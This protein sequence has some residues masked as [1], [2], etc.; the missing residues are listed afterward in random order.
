MDV[1]LDREGEFCQQSWRNMSAESK[2][3]FIIDELKR[4][5]FKA[6]GKKWMLRDG[7]IVRYISS[8]GRQG[9]FGGRGRNRNPVEWWDAECLQLVRDRRRACREYKKCKCI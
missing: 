6:S 4:A 9:R 2:Y 7:R 5:A 3:C 1:L 8:R